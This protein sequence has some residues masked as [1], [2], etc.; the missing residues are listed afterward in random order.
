MEEKG[1]VI[2][3]ENG[4]AQVK[5]ER[6]S[7]CARC[8]ICFKNSEDK[9]ILFAEDSLGVSPGDEVLL[10]VETKQVLKAAFLI[11]LFPLAGLIAGYFLGVKLFRKEAIGILFAGLGFFI[12][13]FFLYQYDKR[14]KA[15]KRREAKIVRI[16]SRF[17]KN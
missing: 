5:M 6:T 1:K 4:V 16:E 14:L 17:R 13:L 8:G 3:V 12:I 9:P 11:Y 2:K 15:G 7:A 10:S